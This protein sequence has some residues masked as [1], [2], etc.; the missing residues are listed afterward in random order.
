MIVPRAVAGSYTSGSSTA[1]RDE[2]S[3]IGKGDDR[4]AELVASLGQPA[5]RF[6]RCAGEALDGRDESD[7]VGRA[8]DDAAPLPRASR[9]RV[10]EP[11]TVRSGPA[12]H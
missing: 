1:T 11:G 7:V 3:A 12:R 4:V 2:E 6:E 8:T 5:G 10:L 9:R